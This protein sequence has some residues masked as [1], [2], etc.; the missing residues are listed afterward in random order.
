MLFRLNPEGALAPA[1]T[2]M[3][4]EDIMLSEIHQLQKTNT[5]WFHSFEEWR[6]AKFMDTELEWWCQF[7]GEGHWGIDFQFCKMRE[8]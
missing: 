7:C 5:V 8:L 2:W 1:P 3:N 6:A 4:L